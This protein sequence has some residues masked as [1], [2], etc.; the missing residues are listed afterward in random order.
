MNLEVIIPRHVFLLHR[1]NDDIY[2][3]TLKLWLYQNSMWVQL[4]VH[5]NFFLITDSKQT[6]SLI[7]FCC[8]QLRTIVIGIQYC[9]QKVYVYC[10]LL[11]YV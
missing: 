6:F 4:Q 10:I 3:V 2:K 1:I 8:Q 11:F 7:I 9:R 5:I